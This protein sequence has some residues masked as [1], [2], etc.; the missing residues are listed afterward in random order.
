M[1]PICITGAQISATLR[2]INARIAAELAA[3]TSRKSSQTR[4]ENHSVKPR[5]K[6]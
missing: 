1:Q 5:T 3:K 6:V 4:K 2:Q